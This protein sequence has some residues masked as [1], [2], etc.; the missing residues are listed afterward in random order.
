M[1]I[2]LGID[3]PIRD[4]WAQQQ[5]VDPE[6]SIAGVSVPEIIPESIDRLV[7]VNGA[8]GVGPALRQ[9]PEIV[10]LGFR[11]EQGIVEPTLRL[12]DVQIGGHDIE[13][14]GEHHG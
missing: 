9:E 13:V 4:R 11:R 1:A 5:M 10:G 8:Q 12:I 2:D 6:A 7:R 14:P 3:Q